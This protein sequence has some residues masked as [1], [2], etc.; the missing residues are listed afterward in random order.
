VTAG[1]EPIRVV[2]VDDDVILAEAISLAW[3]REPDLTIAGLAHTGAEGIALTREIR[4][5]V[6][7]MD[8]HLPDMTGASAT[9]ALSAD[10]SGTAVVIMTIDPTDEALLAAI[11]AGACGFLAKTQGIRAV[12]DVVRRAAA[13]EMLIPAATIARLLALTRQ[14]QRQ[15]LERRALVERLTGRELDVLQLMAQGLDTRAIAE[16][17][18]LGQTTVRTHVASLLGKLGAHT[19]LEAVV[20]ATE[21]GLLT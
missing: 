1:A 4:P 12:A 13:G 6:V 3:E 7:L 20:K 14:R 19:R 10:V 8:H 17:L 5:N 16:R 11:E 18:V 15:E 21:L 2:V 9:A